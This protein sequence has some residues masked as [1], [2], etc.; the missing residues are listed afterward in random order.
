MSEYRCTRFKGRLALFNRLYY[1]LALT[2]SFSNDNDTVSLTV[3]K[4]L[5][6]TVRHFIQIERYF[7][8]QNRFRSRS[9]TCMK[10]N[11]SSVTAHYFYNRRAFM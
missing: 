6:H 7:R 5:S 4:V 2:Y 1:F 8:D 10:S 11:I 3:I 9:K